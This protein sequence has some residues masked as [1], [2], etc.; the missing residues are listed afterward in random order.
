MFRNSI[1]IFDTL[2]YINIL[3]EKHPY[4]ILVIDSLSY[5]LDYDKIVRYNNTKKYNNILEYIKMYHNR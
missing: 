1:D 2:Q 4:S 3:L 5:N